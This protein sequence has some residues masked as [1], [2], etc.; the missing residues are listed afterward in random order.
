[1]SNFK[2]FNR[3]FKI[4][5]LIVLENERLRHGDDDKAEQIF[6]LREAKANKLMFNASMMYYTDMRKFIKER[7]GVEIVS[8]AKKWIKLCW[9]CFAAFENLKKCSKCRAARYCGKE[10]QV[11]DWKTHKVVCTKV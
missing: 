5:S 8:L 4:L 7:F 3:K 11:L 1:M 9:K 6:V 10:C 2:Q